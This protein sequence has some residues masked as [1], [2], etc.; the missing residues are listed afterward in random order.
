MFI[1][2]WLIV[3]VILLLTGLGLWSYLLASGRNPLPF[4]DRGS[5][6]FSAPSPEAKKAIV[7]LLARHGL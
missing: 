7:A 3:L 1:P 6:I 4:P 2:V 5:R